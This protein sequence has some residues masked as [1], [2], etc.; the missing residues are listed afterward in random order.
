MIRLLA[1]LGSAAL[2]IWGVNLAL[3]TGSWREPAA[4]V[5][6]GAA[7]VL[8]AL[9]ETAKLVA[10]PQQLESPTPDDARPAGQSRIA[11]RPEFEPDLGQWGGAA[12][13]RLPAAAPL[14]SDLEPASARE[15]S[16]LRADEIRS[17]LDR[18]M[19]LARGSS[20]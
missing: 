17:R 8:D 11:A 20:P 13:L 14:A 6:E 18:V 1:M 4:R 5:G 2:V 3:D 12:G 7:G 10:R 16:R 19:D 15:L 9:V